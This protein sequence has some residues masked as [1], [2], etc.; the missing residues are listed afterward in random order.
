[1]EQ[2]EIETRKSQ[3][4]AAAWLGGCAAIGL[5]LTGGGGLLMAVVV[6]TS[7]ATAGAVALVA[8]ALAFGALMNAIYRR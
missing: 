4:R 6:E 7:N 5:V 8:S 3:Q 2:P 1:M